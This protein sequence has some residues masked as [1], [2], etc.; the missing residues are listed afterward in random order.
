MKIALHK[1]QLK[2]QLVPPHIHRANKAERAIQ[3][4]KGHLKAGLATVDPDFP[5]HEWDRLLDQCELTLNLLRASRLNP[6]LSA[7]AFLFGEFDYM[8]TPLAPPGTKCL[9]HLKTSQRPTWSP[10]GE[11]GWTIGWSP[12]HYRCIKVFFTKTRSERDCDTITF[13]PTAIPYPEVN[14][15]NFLR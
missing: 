13:F 8:K 10:N 4:M 5:I 3:T 7:W 1:A 6:K 11:E 9:V 2:Y 14:L 12:E 15:D